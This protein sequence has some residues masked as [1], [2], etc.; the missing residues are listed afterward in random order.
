[1]YIDEKVSF[2]IGTDLV[3]MKDPLR[4]IFPGGCYSEP[5]SEKRGDSWVKPITNKRMM[6]D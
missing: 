6:I 5:V 1:M 3:V 2:S 4:L